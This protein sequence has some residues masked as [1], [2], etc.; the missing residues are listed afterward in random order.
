[1]K[2]VTTAGIIVIFSFL[3]GCTVIPQ[4]RGHDSISDALSYVIR[5]DYHSILH[6]KKEL[7]M[8][9]NFNDSTNNVRVSL[10]SKEIYPWFLVDKEDN[11]TGFIPSFQGI[12]LLGYGD[13]K[14]H[15]KLKPIRD[16]MIFLK[17]AKIPESEPD[18]PPLP[19]PC[20]EP[21]IFSF[22]LKNGAFQLVSKTVAD[23]LIH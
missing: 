16:S 8:I 10:L 15:L 1:M 2:Y 21:L 14:S 12:T 11:P 6:S 17:R 9:V 13:A 7:L 20:I 22:E 23:R 18:L 19:P 3:S 5:S 4:N